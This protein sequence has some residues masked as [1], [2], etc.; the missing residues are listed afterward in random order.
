ME[1]LVDGSQT[2]SPLLL[3]LLLLQV[4]AVSQVRPDD[5]RS[6]LPC[7]RAVDVDE[8]RPI[9][10]KMHVKN[11]EEAE[12]KRREGRSRR[13]VEAEQLLCD[14]WRWLADVKL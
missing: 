4:Q 5:A 9:T 12:H 13:R 11:A 7:L 1:E 2:Q 14:A 6:S 8:A 10:H 3:L